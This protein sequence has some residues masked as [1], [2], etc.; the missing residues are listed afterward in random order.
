MKSALDRAINYSEHALFLIEFFKANEG[1]HII[2]LCCLVIKKLK[3]CS[4][5]KNM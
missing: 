5:L 1:S 2:V 3:F 4:M